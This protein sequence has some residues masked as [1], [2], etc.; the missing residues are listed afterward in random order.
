MDLRPTDRRGTPKAPRLANPSDAAALADLGARSFVAKF[1]DLYTPADVDAFL[2]AA[3][4]ESRVAAEIA[5]PEMRVLLAERGDALV[6]YCKVALRCGWPEHARGQRVVE[7]KQLYT[8]P[9]CTGQ[10]VG[11]RLL[12]GALEVA[13][14]FGADEIQLSVFSENVDAQR[15]YARHGFER[16]ADVTFAVGDQ[17]DHDYLFARRLTP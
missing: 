15:F 12:D 6:G 3:H 2:S 10:G 7:L 17:H 8:D 5:D 1:G 9:A 4:S 13:Q 11:S 14:A 16:V